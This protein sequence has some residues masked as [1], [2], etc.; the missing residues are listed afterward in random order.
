[1]SSAAPG[2]KVKPRW[3]LVQLP[4]RDAQIQQNEIG[5]EPG[6]RGKRVGRGVGR[7]DIVDPIVPQSPPADGDC[8][9]IAVDAQDLRPGLEQR[10]GVAAIAQRGVNGPTRPACRRDDRGQEDRHVIG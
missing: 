7:L 1:M 8:L 6:D 4:G 2:R 5:L 10:R 9:G 3:A